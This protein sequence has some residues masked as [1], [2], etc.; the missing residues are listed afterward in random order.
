MTQLNP[1]FQTDSNGQP[2]VIL[3]QREYQRILRE[4]QE[5]Q[6]ELEDIKDFDEAMQKDDGK[7]YTMEEVFGE[8]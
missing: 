4:M 2:I 7:R 5:M 8:N 3:P 1:K 6:D